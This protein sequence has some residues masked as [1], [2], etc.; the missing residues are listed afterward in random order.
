MQCPKCRHEQP[1]GGAVCGACG[2]VFEKY[3]RYHPRPG[4]PAHLAAARIR[5]ARAGQRGRPGARAAPAEGTGPDGGTLGG[6]LLPSH[7]SGGWPGLWARAALWGVL[8]AWG[9]WFITASI[10]DN[11]AGRSVWHLVNLPFHEFGHI[12]FRPFGDWVTSLGGT[13]GQLL[14]PAI[15][16]GVLL[17]Q[18]RDPFGASAAL[19]WLGQSFIDIA[20]YINDA[21]AGE[22]PLLGGNFGHSAPYGFHDWEFILGETGLLAWDHALARTSH[23]IGSLVILTALAWGALVLWSQLTQ[24]RRGP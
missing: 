13:L 12:L 14:M 24:L 1:D 4:E 21:R 22:L 23:A 9:L 5:A 16:C 6:L 8:L 10:Q 20:P 7:H 18:T 15:C 11:D 3:Y 19:W 2:L 17:L